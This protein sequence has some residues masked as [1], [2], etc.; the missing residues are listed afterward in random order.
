MRINLLIFIATMLTT[1]LLA[2]CAVAQSDTGM[3]SYEVTIPIN[4]YES[5]NVGNLSILIQAPIRSKQGPIPLT[6]ILTDNIQI[7][8]DSA[9]SYETT[10]AATKV[11]QGYWSGWLTYTGLGPSTC[12]GHTDNVVYTISYVVDGNG[13]PHGISALWDKWGCRAAVD[14]FTQDNSGYELVIPRGT[15]SNPPY[16]ATVYDKS[17][18]SAS[19]VWAGAHGAGTITDTHGNQVTV[20]NPGGT[21]SYTDPLTTTAVL[22]YPT[23]MSNFTYTDGVGN[24]QNITYG[25]YSGTF[26]PAFSCAGVTNSSLP[27]TLPKT[28]TYPNGGAIAF[29]WEKTGAGNYDGRLATLQ[30]PAGATYTHS[31]TSGT[32]ND[33]LWC[34][35]NHTVA[36]ATLNVSNSVGTWSFARNSTGS[37]TTV[38]KPDGSK[39]VY[40]FGS[41]PNIV[42]S[43]VIMDTDGATILDTWTYCFDS[44]ISNCNPSPPTQHPTWVRA[45][46]SVPGVSGNAEVDTQYDTY[47][48]VT[49]VDRYDF[50]PTLVNKHFLFRGNYNTSTGVCDAAPPHIAGML[51]AS[52]VEDASSNLIS[53]TNYKY[54]SAGDLLTAYHYSSGSSSLSETF[55]YNSNGTVATHTAVDGVQATFGNTQ[56]NGFMPDHAT[57][58]I[59]TV[60]MTWD[61]N[62]GVPA[63]T[64]G[65]NNLTTTFTYGDPLYRI[66]NMH[67][68]GG[69]AD[70][71]YTYTSPTRFS[72]DMTFNSN[73]SII[74]KTTTLDSQGRTSSVQRKQ[75]PTSS[76]YDTVSFTYDASG[77]LA[78]TSQ[79]CTTTAGGTCTNAAITY[80]YDGM[81]RLLTKTVQTSPNGVLTYSYPNGDTKITVSPAPSG[82]NNKVTQIE[83]DGLGR[84]IRICQVASLGGS[85]SCGERT[86]ASGYETAFNLD[87]L[88][89]PTQIARNA[90]QGGT[91]VSTFFTYDFLNRVTSKTIPEEGTVN[92]TYDSSTTNCSSFLAGHLTQIQDNDGNYTCMGYDSMG[93]ITVTTVNAGPYSSASKVNQFVYDSN[94]K[95][96]AHA[97]GKLAEVYTCVWPCTT[98]I[99]DEQFGYDSY[100]RMSDLWQNSPTLGSGNYF[101]TSLTYWD[102]GEPGT[103]SGLPGLSNVGYTPDGEGR[104]SSTG[105]GTSTTVTCGLSYDAAS[106]P[107]SLTYGCGGDSDSY[108]WDPNSS[109]LTQY[110]FVLNG[111]TDKGVPTW[112]PNGTLQQFQV[113]DNLSSS[114]TQTCTTAH[115]DLARITSFAGGSC[116]MSESYSYS[117]DYA[118]NVTKSGTFNFNP[119]YVSATNRFSSGFGATYDLN[120]NITHDPTLGIN[121]TWDA[122]GNMLSEG[123]NTIVNDGLGRMVEQTVSGTTTYY[124]QSPLGTLGTASGLNTSKNIRVP[125]PAGAMMIFSGA[126]QYINHFGFNSAPMVSNF[127][128]R[129]LKGVYSYGPMGELYVGSA[130]GSAYEGDSFEDTVNGLQDYGS[131]RYS[132]TWGRSIHPTGGSNGYLKTNSP[133]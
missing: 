81:N 105:Y 78:S 122:Y 12:N 3:P 21:F 106:R 18:K 38:T 114:D 73:N 131:I 104:P 125:L 75:A 43:K 92:Y 11:A 93:R 77:H 129:T 56:C 49:E 74:D 55:T 40:S 60:S 20:A 121:Y 85:G 101:H 132:G 61:C 25:T 31:Y 88:G 35:A 54:S 80:I 72:S 62:G 1:L 30:I 84:T 27:I 9:S 98:K 57:T 8:T 126:N 46:H 67:D 115:D 100:G 118:G 16:T 111:V 96:G 69:Q 50:G 42:T 113:T 45:Y 23:V 109:L 17:G 117:T 15:G 107:L 97:K 6:F 66:T 29:T 26:F 53:A 65:L 28:V 33:G 130:P 124:L 44:T 24:Q 13:T 63:T 103:L 123:G 120:G 7:Y 90:Q 64:T 52:D 71:T 47:G 95:G 128:A 70:V 127:P 76:N 41:S 39:I 89:R 36:N 14:V 82:E 112:N 37:Q 51:C 32:N 19:F 59:G 102:N 10:A 108:T 116:K 58:S 83:T 4:A 91:W 86:A 99:T 48:N 94:S 119:G 34:L 5:V 79:A 68:N 110:Q 133:F 22:S 87:A 2:V